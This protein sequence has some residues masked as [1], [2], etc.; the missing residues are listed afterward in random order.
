MSNTRSASSA[1]HHKKIGPLGIALLVGAIL[2]LFAF[3]LKDILIPVL[4]LE[5]EKDVEG[6]AAL[7]QD[8]GIQGYL[9]VILVEALQMV[10]VFIPAEFIQISSALSFPFPLAVLL[11]DLGVCLGAS[12][13]FILVRIY[14]VRNDAYEKQQQNIAEF[15]DIVHERNTVFL[16]YFLF[17][18]PLIPFGAICYY[19]SGR[20]LPY[21]KYIRTVATGVLPS[22][23]TSNLMGAVGL[24]FLRS[25]LPL[26]VLVLIIVFFALLLFTAGILVIRRFYFRDK[27]GTPESMTSLL[28]FFVIRLIMMNRQKLVIRD[29]K[30]EEAGTPYI[31]LVNHES[32]FDFYYVS[33]MHHPKNPA[34]LM[35]EHY[36]SR[37]VARR[38]T[39]SM[40]IIPKKLFYPDMVSVAGIMRTIRSG[41]PVVIFPEARL[42]PDGCSNEI[43]ERGAAFYQKLG[44]DLVLTKLSGAYFA[45]PKWRKRMYRSRVTVSVERVLKKEELSAMSPEALDALIASTL[46]QDAS[47]STFTHYRQN[48]KAAGLEQILYRCADC[49]SLYTTVSRKNTLSCTKCK[50]SHTLDETY[51]FV[52]GPPTISAYYGRIRAMEEEEADHFVLEADVRVKIFGANGGPTRKER[53][54][55]RLDPS[56]FRYVSSSC[57]FTIPADRFPALAFSCGKEFEFYHM[58]ELY[59]FYPL[60]D[61]NQV[62]RWAVF[63]D[64]LSK[65]RRADAH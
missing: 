26:W 44:C 64:I 49:G 35:N 62:V 43:V 46:Y 38:I 20:K 52:S 51:H 58:N 45:K 63:I 40:G 6:A 28:V 22:I 54:H 42:S 15:S 24:A 12:I 11:C 23:V 30:L 53:G 9:T 34:Y 39:R 2:F 14:H 8:R 29:E 1:S 25:R 19:G 18:M 5:L 27:A 32:F 61:P 56:G 41:Y 4:K 33:R 13:I 36:T 48:T 31:M 21:G 16:L 17:I 55:C 47:S 57:D 59:Y 37:P 10:V 3:F 50:A 65:K 7:I 60:K